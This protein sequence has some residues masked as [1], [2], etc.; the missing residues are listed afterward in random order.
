MPLAYNSP[1]VGGCRLKNATPSDV[2]I[3]C[4]RA[5]VSTNTFDS[6]QIDISCSTQGGRC[7]WVQVRRHQTT[8]Q[9]LHWQ[10]CGY[11]ECD[12]WRSLYFIVT[13]GSDSRCRSSTVG[14][15]QHF[16][17]KLRRTRDTI[18]ASLLSTTGPVHC[19]HRRAGQTLSWLS[20]T[21]AGEVLKT[22]K[23]SGL[24]WSPVDVLPA[25][26]LPSS[27]DVFAPIFA[28]IANLKHSH[29]LSSK[30]GFI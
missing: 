27:A 24:K 16:A 26:P 28:H 10:L 21:T 15:S 25:R 30:L 5:T 9:R 19:S 17:D 6:R 1:T 4:V 12:P 11:L 2:V 7:D 20:S 23:S 18:S 14:F 29:C 13:V 3:V 22:L 8:F